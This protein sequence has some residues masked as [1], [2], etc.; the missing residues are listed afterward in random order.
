MYS[1]SGTINGFHV[2]FVIDTGATL[3]SMN[4]NVAKRIGLDYKLKGKE[5]VSYTA[6]GK[7]KVYIVNLNPSLTLFA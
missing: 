1:I 2:A 5:S 6:S 3:V 4:S 7:D